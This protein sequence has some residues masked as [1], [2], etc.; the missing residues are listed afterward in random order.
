MFGSSGSIRS[1]E[2]GPP[3][4]APGSLRRLWVSC[5]MSVRMLGRRARWRAM[6]SWEVDK[7]LGL[8]GELDLGT[9]ADG[10]Q[11]IL[12]GDG[13]TGGEGPHRRLWDLNLLG[14]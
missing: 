4:L 1:G 5:S 13:F 7:G 14:G 3:P 10:F 8:G 11:D 12:G 9:G 2:Y 6:E